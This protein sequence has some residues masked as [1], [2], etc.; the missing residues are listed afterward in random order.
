MLYRDLERI[1]ARDPE[2]EVR[3]MAVPVL[4][5]CLQAFKEFVPDDPIVAAIRDVVSADAIA[6]GDPVRVV[7][8]VLVAGQLAAAIG[9]EKV[10]VEPQVASIVKRRPSETNLWD[11][12]F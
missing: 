11:V 3:G 4:D 12:Q 6:E 10:P 5:A 7:D 2:Q 1:A 9:A 8:A